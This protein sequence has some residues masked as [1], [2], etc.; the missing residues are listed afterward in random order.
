M[1]N[2][3]ECFCGE[4]RILNNRRQ[5]PFKDQLPKYEPAAHSYLGIERPMFERYLAAH[6]NIGS[7][8]LAAKGAVVG[9]FKVAEALRIKYD[10]PMPFLCTFTDLDR[11]NVSFDKLFSTESLK[12]CDS[13]LCVHMEVLSIEQ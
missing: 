13:D 4:R 9:H 12:A 8:T 3:Y 11:I 10:C 5:C 6:L 7:Q 1:V 2:V